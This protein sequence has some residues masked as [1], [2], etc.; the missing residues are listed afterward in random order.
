MAVEEVLMP[1]EGVNSISIL[2]RDL[3]LVDVGGGVETHLAATDDSPTAR[4][5]LAEGRLDASAAPRPLATRKL[6]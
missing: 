6:P 1:A 5:A 2:G 3:L 4:A